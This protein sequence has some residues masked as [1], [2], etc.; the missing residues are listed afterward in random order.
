MID[1]NGSYSY[2][3][4]V[5]LKSSASSILSVFPNLALNS[6]TLSHPKAVN[7]TLSV[8]AISGKKVSQLS[9]TEGATLTSINV[10]NLPK[11]TYN[12]AFSNKGIVTTTKFVK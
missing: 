8:I 1:N 3:S 9:I 10:S 6:I 11:G 5:V 2:S 12:V 7:A 4:I